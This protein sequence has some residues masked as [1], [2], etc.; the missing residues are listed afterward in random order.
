MHSSNKRLPQLDIFCIHSVVTNTAKLWLG[1]FPATPNGL[2]PVLVYCQIG[3]HKKNCHIFYGWM[4]V[5]GSFGSES[6]PTSSCHKNN[7]PNYVAAYKT[8]IQE[9][10]AD[11]TAKECLAIRQTFFCCQIG[12]QFCCHFFQPRTD[13]IITSPSL[14]HLQLWVLTPYKMTQNEISPIQTK[15]PPIESPCSRGLRTTPN[16]V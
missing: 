7:I 6:H 10:T 2:R 1:P 4:T 14:V 12:C 15:V 8:N 5:I 11:L 13:C 3:C 9:L 16:F